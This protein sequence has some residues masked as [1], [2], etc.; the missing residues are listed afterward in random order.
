[1]TDDEAQKLRDE[2]AR[3]RDLWLHA[4]DERDALA[5]KLAERDEMLEQAQDREDLAW[6]HAE[7]WREHA[8]ATEAELEEQRREHAALVK[9]EVERLTAREPRRRGRPPSW[10]PDSEAEVERRHRGGAS[11]RDR[12]RVARQQDAGSPRHR[13]CAPATCRGCGARAADRD[14]GWPEPNATRRPCGQA[15]ERH[16]IE[17]YNAARVERARERL[18]QS[19]T[20]DEIEE[21]DEA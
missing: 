18:R 16:P 7:F 11:P 9:L 5:E 14:R 4:A 3:Y 21:A 19:V 15:A 8:E 10:S 1:M 17:D 13:S 2:R 12:R 6:E 20:V